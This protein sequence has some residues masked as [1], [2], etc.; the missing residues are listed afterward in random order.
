MLRRFI[1]AFLLLSVCATTSVTRA[2]TAAA[3]PQEQP[4]PATAPAPAKNDYSNPDFWLCRT[5]RY[6]ACDIDLT[7]TIVAADGK[8]T[9]ETWRANPKVPIDCFYVYPTVSNDPTPNSDMIPG[10]EEKSVIE[11]QFARFA[12]QCRPFAPM[13]RQATLTALRSS[14][15][16][17]PMKPDRALAYNDVLDAW[18][19]YLAHDN[20]GRG[21][22]LIG[23][24]QGANVLMKLIKNEID[25]KPEQTHIISAMLLGA[26]TPVPQ[27]KDVGGAFQTMP[28]CRSAAQ[29]GCIISYVTFR[30]NVLP[31]SNT[32]FGKVAGD[33]LVAA[34]TNPASLAGGS[35]ELHAYLNSKGSF[36]SDATAEQRPWVTPQQAI[37]TPF[38]SVPGLL[39]AECVSNEHGSYL[40]VTVHGD[41]AGPRSSEI[42]GDVV[43]G[44][45]VLKEWGLHLIDVQVAIG[46]LV[47]IV[48]Q[49]SKAYLDAIKK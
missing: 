13:Y 43:V 10:P 3:P 17:N 9:R 25:G 18:N 46:N 44:G 5:G 40:A 48:G 23:H 49:E 39:T 26:N 21:V 11:A 15:T 33:G 29:T 22:V 45:T 27:G 35:G 16:G 12:S 4:K 37:D 19:Y 47:D 14:Y 7:T 32:L 28:L 6:D 1:A 41:P 34:C 31:P 38:V 42:V 36:V 24:S 2:Q 20:K 30:A 8:L